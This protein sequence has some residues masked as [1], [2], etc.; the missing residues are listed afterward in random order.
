[1]FY[2][3]GTSG[4]PT[5]PITCQAESHALTEQDHTAADF[6]CHEYARTPKQAQMFVE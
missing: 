5:T 2:H 4:L 3:P 6:V 1:M